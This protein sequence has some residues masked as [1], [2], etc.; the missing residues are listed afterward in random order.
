M[1]RLKRAIG[2]ART[3]PHEIV[4]AHC[5][6]A[7]EKSTDSKAPDRSFEGLDVS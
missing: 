4:T 5:D 6:K 1:V 2:Y 7:N 3:F